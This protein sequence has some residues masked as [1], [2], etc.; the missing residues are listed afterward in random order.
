MDAI[1]TTWGEG[2]APF[3]VTKA[4]VVAANVVEGWDEP[5]ELEYLDW[6]WFEIVPPSA[7]CW[8]KGDA[9]G[10]PLNG[11]ERS[12][13]D[14]LNINKKSKCIVDII[15]HCIDWLYFGR[16]IL[17]VNVLQGFIVYESFADVK[18]HNNI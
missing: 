8:L 12:K 3:A 5:E 9:D 10:P 2:G 17:P 14:E 1:G 4:L 16:I 15:V 6:S 18:A 7:C 11:S 13:L